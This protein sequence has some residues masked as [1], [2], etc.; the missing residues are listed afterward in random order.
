VES[1]TVTT[2]PADPSFGSAPANGY[3]VIVKVSATADP[4]YTSG[5][6]VN[7]LDFYALEGGHQ[8]S[9][10]NGNAFQALSN[11]QSNQDIT[12]TLGAGNTSSGWIAFDVPRPHGYIVYAPNFDGQPLAEWHF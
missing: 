12:A 7:S 9:E 1:A 5:F 6:E 10:G 3:Y 11:G 4:S 8:Y 2:Q